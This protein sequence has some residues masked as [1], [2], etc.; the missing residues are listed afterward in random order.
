MSN[1]ICLAPWFGIYI[2]TIFIKPC[3]MWNVGEKRSKEHSWKSIDDIEKIWN[4]KAMQTIRESFLNGTTPEACFKCVD[5]M[6]T[7]RV[8]LN[9]KIGKYVKSKRFTLSPP[10]KPLHVELQLG[11]KC[12]I[13]CRSCRSYSSSSWIKDDYTLGKIDPALDRQVVNE[14]KLDV[15]FKD[16]KEMFSDVVRFDFKGGEP[17]VHNNGVEMIE[18]LVRWGI[19]P[20]IILAYVTNGSF[21]NRDMMN[22]W[23]NFK[24]LKM[25]MSIDGTGDLFSY[26]RSFNFEKFEETLNIYD[27]IENLDGAYNT[28]ISIYNILDLA[29]INHWIMT[30][31]FKR[32]P[33][34]DSQRS[35]L[36][37]CNVTDP[38]YLNVTILPKKYKQLAL[39]RI[40]KYDY[41]NIPFLAEWLKSIQ[42]IPP[43]EEQLKLFVS[44]TR[45]M[46]RIKGTNFLSIKPEFE[47]LFKEY[48]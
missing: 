5:R 42:D 46:D 30:R 8:W 39:E 35:T 21:V 11:N 25:V 45:E 9:D 14:Y 31:H 48:C 33:C 7:R 34:L 4:G 26:T 17:M 23:D 41:P 13:Q 38:T 19:A 24:Q 28:A 1:N 37:E 36:F 47:D 3:C 44:F 18:N 29:E 2:G 10:L 6:V 40:Y 43:N 15:S 27:Q 22:L 16:S 20:N 32:F 12:N